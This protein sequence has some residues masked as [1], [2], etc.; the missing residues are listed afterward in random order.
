MLSRV[1][2]NIYW[3]ARY[4][5]RAENTARLINVTSNLVLDLPKKIPFEWGA[6]ADITGSSALFNERHAAADERTVVKFLVGDVNNPGS[7]IRSLDS[8]RENARTIR[9]IIPREAWEQINHLYM[10]CKSNLQLGLSRQGRYD[11]LRWAILGT[12]TITGMLAGTMNHDAG[13]DFLRVGRNLERADMTTRIIDVRSANLLAEQAS[14]LAPFENIQWMSVLK[15]LTGYQMYRRTMQVRVR[16]PDVLRFL[17]QD[18]RFPRAF[19]HTVCEVESCLRD[20]PRNDAPL[21]LI[22]QLQR[23]VSDSKPER[24]NPVE[25]H[26]FMDELQAHLAEVHDQISATY[27][28]T[29]L[30]ATA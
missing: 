15:S 23:L 18:R 2:E 1:A 7:V 14:D 3:L 24:L 8:A 13:Y 4:I 30:P 27:F 10:R 21:R 25:L 26:H 17:I 11:Y 19:Y 22:T 29:A 5:E 20:L 28:S 12:Q 9:D 6:L 16:R